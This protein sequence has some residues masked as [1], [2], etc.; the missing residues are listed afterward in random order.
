MVKD[1]VLLLGLILLSVK[2]FAQ[3]PDTPKIR[4]DTINVPQR[5][6]AYAADKIAVIRPLNIEL[7]LPAP[8]NFS[9]KRGNTPLKDGKVN[10]FTQL[11]ISA[12]INLLKKNT[13][14]LGAT[15]GYRFTST[16]SNMFDPVT[17][18]PIVLQEDFH[19][20]FSSLDFTYFSTLFNKTTIY[21]ASVIVEGSN[22]HLERVKALFTAVMVLKGT[23]KTKIALGVAVNIDPTGQMPVIPVFTYEHRFY[24]SLI[25]DVTLPK[26]AYLRKYLFKNAGRVSLGS[27]L[28]QTTFYVY[29]MDGNNPDQRFQYAQLDI[30]SGIM[31]EHAIGD[32]VIT[33]KTGLKLTPSGR[34]F[35]KEDNI[36][37]AVFE[38]KPD[39][40]FYFNVGVSFNPFTFLK[41]NK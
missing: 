15:V 39:P 24:N 36:G 23:Q 35:R 5:T 38:L 7:S 13:W 34:L 6:V 10:D 28:E 26:S 27:E 14:M 22:Q 17:D 30:N 18:N 11:K 31:Y 33:G 20:L 40:M 25:V 2:G 12:N 37:D 29:N 9:S 19:Y 1:A 32:F 41:K 16:E 21:G 8:Y 3:K 4:K